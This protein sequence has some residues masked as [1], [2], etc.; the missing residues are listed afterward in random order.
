MRN[1][2]LS[3]ALLVALAGCKD[4]ESI[5]AA[6][7]DAATDAD[8]AADADPFSPTTGQWIY[9]EFG[10][11][12]STCSAVDSLIETDARGSAPWL[13]AVL[14]CDD[15]G[16]RLCTS[17]E[18]LAACSLGLLSDATDDAEWTGEL[19]TPGFAMVVLGSTCTT[20]TTGAFVATHAYRCC[21]D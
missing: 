8:T 14:N 12:S 3:G 9:S 15:E 1:L 6:E 18:L 13:D 10:I 21:Q 11:T 2:I 5:T 7:A 19:S 20:T 17:Q 4:K 16:R